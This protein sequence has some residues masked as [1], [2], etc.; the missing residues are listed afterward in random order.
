MRPRVF[1]LT[2]LL[3]VALVALGYR[4]S[5][6]ALAAGVGQGLVAQRGKR[7]PEL[8]AGLATLDG[9]PLHLADLRGRV[10]LLHFW[11]FG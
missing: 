4:S 5:L 8:P 7:A 9:R 3:L 1:V 6:Q 2:A 11:T 10:V